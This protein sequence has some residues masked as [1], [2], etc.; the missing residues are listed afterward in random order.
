M[1][2]LSQLQYINF[3]DD[4]PLTRYAK[5]PIVDA[6]GKPVTFSPPPTSKETAS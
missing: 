5:L 1:C 6:P 3:V 4:G 2:N